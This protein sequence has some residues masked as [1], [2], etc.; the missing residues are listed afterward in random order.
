MAGTPPD[1]L[2][3]V[4]GIYEN[5]SQAEDVL[6]QLV[7]YGFTRDRLEIIDGGVRAEQKPG[8]KPDSD[9]VRN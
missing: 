6:E 5:R 7:R 8:T 2:H 3:R 9:E 4:T 1:Y